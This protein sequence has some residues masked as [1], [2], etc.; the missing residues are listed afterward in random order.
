MGYR[1]L[2]L[3][4]AVCLTAAGQGQTLTVD[5]LSAFLKNATTDSQHKY[6]DTELAAF[7]ARV[8]LSER[9]DDRTL[10]GLQSQLSL[11]AKTI[12]ALHKLRDQSQSLPAAAPPAAPEAL[13]PIPVP[14]AQEQAAILEDVRKYALSYSENLPDF[15]CTEVE[16]RFGAQPVTAGTPGWRQL[17]ELTKRLTYF[18]QKEDY[19]LIMR[20]NTVAANQDVKSAGGSQSFG[21]FGSMMRQVFEPMT[22]AFFEW[23]SWHT[24]RGQ[25]VMSF[26]YRV[27]LERSRYHITYEKDRDIITAYHGWF[28]VDPASHV[29]LRIAVVA[30]NIPPDFPVKSASDI[31][32]YDYQDLSGQTFLLPLKAEIQMSEGDFLTK[33]NKEFKIY[34]KYSAD[35]LIKYDGDFGAPAVDCKDPKNK[36]AKECKPAVPIKH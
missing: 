27:S 15:I 25:R 22:Q 19:K 26:K 10:E 24:L 4:L 23:D 29:V 28:D 7:L 18:E 32:D 8:K 17:D 16:R 30:E 13:R 11:G 36:D 34:R 1:I 5:K 2:A 33:N 31:L 35:A 14:S 6:S 21:D 3:A 12:A 9:L 20:N